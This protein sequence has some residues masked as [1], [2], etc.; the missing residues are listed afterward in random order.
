M[1]ARRALLRGAF[2]TLVPSRS[3][4]R[5]ALER[6]RLPA[7][8][9]RYIASGVDLERF[10]PAAR[11]AGGLRQAWGAGDRTVVFGSVG[12]LRPEKNPGH[13]LRAFAAADVPDSLLALV[14]DGPERAPLARLSNELGIAGR[15]RFAGATQD[16]PACYAA[17]DVFLM[18]S[19]TEQMPMAMLEAMAC[20]LPVVCTDVGDSAE[21]AGAGWPPQIVPVDDLDAYVVARRRLAADAALR[22]ELGGANAARCRLRYGF[23]RMAGEYGEAYRE[24][25]AGAEGVRR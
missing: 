6:Y 21:M 3:L 5:I 23:Q 13:M 11:A 16:T 22:R 20:G 17:F 10:R 15:V 7:S 18:S 1:L 19:L 12:L 14:G 8:K 9:V 2:R 4:E 24:A 25:L